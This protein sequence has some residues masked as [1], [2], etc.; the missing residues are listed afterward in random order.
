MTSWSGALRLLHLTLVGGGLIPLAVGG[1]VLS[2]IAFLA[3]WHGAWIV[4]GSPPRYHESSVPALPFQLA[5]LIGAVVPSV[6]VMRLVQGC[7]CDTARVIGILSLSLV[8]AVGTYWSPL[9]IEG[10]PRLL[11][12][13]L[14]AQCAGTIGGLMLLRSESCCRFALSRIRFENSAAAHEAPPTSPGC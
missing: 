4:L 10:L 9:M 3:A 5:A 1:A 8:S 11:S 6:L 12:S 2:T 14:A 7:W 13:A